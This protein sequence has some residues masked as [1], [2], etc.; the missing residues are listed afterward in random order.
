MTGAAG[1]IGRALRA[2][3]AD[4]GV[5]LVS[6]D[7]REPAAVST[8]DHVLQTDI[9][10]PVALDVAFDGCDGVVH[11]AGI[12]DEADFH[13][14]AEVNIVGTYHVL[15]A[16]RRAGVGRVVSAGRNRVTGAYDVDTIVD[17]SMPPRPDGFF[18]VSK[19][20]V[21]ALSR[22]YADKFGLRTVVIRIGSYEAPLDGAR[23]AHLAEPGRRTSRVRRR[24]DHRAP[25]RGVLRGVREPRPM[26]ECRGGGGRRVPA[27]R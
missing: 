18:G 3:L 19:V 16:A 14:L 10:D 27:R 11:L 15:E 13:D 21:E 24:D 17:E 6:I 1:N 4:Q 2:H 7:L 23:D 20:A 25:T 22:L 5:A 12:A 8:D 9:G 26:V